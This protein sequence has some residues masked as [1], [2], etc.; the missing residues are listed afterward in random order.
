SCVHRTMHLLSLPTTSACW[1][2]LFRILY[3]YYTK[4]VS[5]VQGP[6]NWL[7]SW[8]KKDT[9]GL[10]KPLTQ[11]GQ[12]EKARRNHDYNSKRL[13]I[14]PVNQDLRGQFT[15]GRSPLVG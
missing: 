12:F 4:D 7:W 14:F 3:T 11:K 1:N 13:I 15:V 2:T 5:Y 6:K 9:T 8:R 10:R